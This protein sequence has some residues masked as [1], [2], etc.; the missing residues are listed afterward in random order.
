MCNIILCPLCIYISVN[1]R[2]YSDLKQ[3][4]GRFFF[5][6]KHI[7]TWFKWLLWSSIVAI[8]LLIAMQLCKICE[9]YS[10]KH[11]CLCNRAIQLSSYCILLH[12]IYLGSS[13][14]VNI[15]WSSYDI[16]CLFN[17]PSVNLCYNCSCFIS[18]FIV[19]Y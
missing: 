9:V 19:F 10:L 14:F 13:S 3:V 16:Q 7:F 4:F 6:Y 18:S 15:F 1:T 8:V 11:V 2:K 17:P 12:V 5:Y